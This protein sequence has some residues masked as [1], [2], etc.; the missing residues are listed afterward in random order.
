MY[1]C[2]LVPRAHDDVIFIAE[3]RAIKMAL[4][5][6]LVSCPAVHAPGGKHFVAWFEF[7][8]TKVCLVN[9]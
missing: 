4:S 7:I 5:C 6:A 8:V 1:T 9:T 3:A 2:S